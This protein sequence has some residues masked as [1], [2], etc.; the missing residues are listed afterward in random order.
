MLPTSEKV[1]EAVQKNIYEVAMP[2][3][4]SVVLLFSTT[5]SRTITMYLQKAEERHP[6][7]LDEIDFWL[8]HAARPGYS[9]SHEYSDNKGMLTV[10]LMVA[11]EDAE[12]AKMHRMIEDDIYPV[13]AFTER[14]LT[15]SGV[16]EIN[17]VAIAQAAFSAARSVVDRIT[18]GLTN[19]YESELV[20]HYTTDSVVFKLLQQLLQ[21][22]EKHNVIVDV[23]LKCKAAGNP[24]L[25][26]TYTAKE[27][28]AKRVC[29]R[30]FN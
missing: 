23:V 27:P 8:T 4:R 25:T 12:V 1:L 5:P 13:Y 26:V 19:T 18:V 2:L 24:K 11:S 20:S 28:V 17:N 9:F 15:A 21:R 6:A 29:Q 16:A 14:S 10:T 22:T 3:I 30:I 7:T